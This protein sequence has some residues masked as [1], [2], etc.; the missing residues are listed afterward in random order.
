M[1][2]SPLS[3]SAA[4]SLLAALVS[5]L[6]LSD[7][8]VLVSVAPLLLLVSVELLPHPERRD[9]VTA[10]ATAS[11]AKYSVGNYVTF[12]HYPQTSAGNDSSAIKWLVLARDGNKVLLLSRYGLDMKPYNTQ[13]TD[14]TWEKCTLR[15]WLNGTF[16]N[17]A[18]TAPE[19][20]G[21]LLTNVDNSKS[22]GY[23]GWDTNGGNNTQDK[24]FLLS[25]AETNKYLGVTWGSNNMK[26]R[27]VLT[28]YAVKQG[29]YTS[30][31]NNVADGTTAEWWWLRSP[32]SDQRHAARVLADGSLNNR[33]VSDVKG[34]IRPALWINLKSDI[35]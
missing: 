29:A 35:F 25:Y 13:Y 6:P 28:A 21:I 5:V 7:A 18:F 16:L 26:P 24:I 22:Q 30:S 9:A 31:S 2:V 27:I 23:S 15:T 19:Q 32:G 3:V 8:S 10:V 11:E 12:G 20:A 4:L 1:Y 17:K 33:N 14:I 34:F